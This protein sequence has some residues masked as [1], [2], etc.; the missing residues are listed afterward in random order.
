MSCNFRLL[1]GEDEHMS[2]STILVLAKIYACSKGDAEGQGHRE[3]HWEKLVCFK[4]IKAIQM[5]GKLSNGS[6]K[7]KLDHDG[8]RY[9]T[10]VGRADDSGGGPR[11]NS[12]KG[13]TLMS[14]VGVHMV[15]VLRGIM[16]KGY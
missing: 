5:K 6:R 2:F 7:R 12:T 14:L 4:S 9:L 8:K 11:S 13:V 10:T 15:L 1:S 16:T 3:I